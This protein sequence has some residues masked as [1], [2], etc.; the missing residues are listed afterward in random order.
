MLA[1]P[2][3]PLTVVIP[4]TVPAAPI[5]PCKTAVDPMPSGLRT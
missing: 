5:V 1:Y 4:V 3:P 2:L